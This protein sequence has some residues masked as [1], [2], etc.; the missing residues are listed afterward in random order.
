MKISTK[1]RYA[2]KL[3]ID[4]AV[5]EHSGNVSIKDVSERRNISVKYLE[6]IVGALSRSGF[7]KSQRGAQGGYQLVKSA[8]KYTVGSIIRA[9]E[10]E[11]SDDYI[12][13]EDIS[14]S[15]FWHGLYDA[16]NNYIDSVTISDLIEE[17]KQNEEVYEYFI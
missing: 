2:I 6:Q 7:V 9:M 10:G 3:M 15:S 13:E 17:A 4:I 8:D 12:D 16:I 5:N 14:L 1:S 11:I